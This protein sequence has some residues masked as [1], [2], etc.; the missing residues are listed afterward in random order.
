LLDGEDGVSGYSAIA[1]YAIIGDCHSAALISRAGSIDWLCLPRFD[2]P[3]LF[4]AL[5]DAE[6]GGRFF[7]RP[8]GSFHCR[9]Q[10]IGDS[11]VLESTFETD[12]G[13]LRLTDLMPVRSEEAK[14][15][16]LS[17][18]HEVL[19]KVEC[20]AGSVEVAVSCDPRPSYGRVVPR[21]SDRGPL[22]FVSE[23]GSQLLVL[24]SEIPLQLRQDR[25]GVA[26]TATLQA[27]ERR[28]ISLVYAVRE[29]AVMPPLGDLAEARVQASIRWWQGWADGCRYEG[30]Y[31]VQIVRSALTLKLMMYAPSGALVAAPTTSLPEHIGG[32]RNWDYRYCWLRDAELTVGALFDLEQRTEA[33]AFVS[34]MIHATR[35]R[36][37]DLQVMYD[38]FGET[39]LTERTL[40]Y[41]D[42]YE[43]SR[44]VRIGNGAH[45]QL[46]LDVYGQ[47]VDSAYQFF[48]RGGRLESISTA[49][50]V[51]LGEIVCDRWREPDEGIWE[52]RSGRRQHTV[53]KA[54]CWVTLDR[55]LRLQT[56]HGLKMPA[57]KFARERTAIAKEI[58]SHGWSSALQSY[59]ATF[60]SEDIDASLLLLG[61]HGYAGAKSPRMRATLSRVWRELGS[62][63]LLYRYR[64]A[65]DGLPEGDGTFTLCGFWAV[66]LR[67]RSGELQ[68]A[69]QEFER[70][71][72]IANDVG[73]FAEEH[74]VH[75]GAALGNFPQAFTHAGLISAA[76]A[77]QR[78]GLDRM[79][80]ARAKT[81]ERASVEV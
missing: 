27:G 46:Q 18:N 47:V 7:I 42:G 28:F 2:S 25:P 61:L 70:I 36:R 67:A 31:R 59:V 5:L 37:H 58:E 40:P 1:D 79:E 9:R 80:Q 78:P 62:D 77:L 43:H 44:P 4:G 26:G 55:L 66:E 30:P 81:E 75:S 50:L 48:A 32:V 19:R 33:E 13:V 64:G 11:N 41:L 21:I 45:D 54:M 15:Y 14:R 56:E 6:K 63:G 68:R 20:L 74:D 16:Q 65:D 71:L 57:Q 3:S 72:R 29:P 35:S 17:P 24:R 49:R 52:I 10:Y 76:L 51:E 8:R 12:T 39:R 53:S 34:W 23:H 60:D 69:S 22:G 73:L 38:V